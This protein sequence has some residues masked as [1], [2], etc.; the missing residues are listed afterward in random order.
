MN[1]AVIPKIIWLLITFTPTT[2][3]DPISVSRVADEHTCRLLE[4]AYEGFQVVRCIPFETR[5]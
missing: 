1:G 5:K 2:P 3:A 4:R